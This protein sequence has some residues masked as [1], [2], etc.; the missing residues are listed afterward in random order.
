MAKLTLDLTGSAGL[1]SK[2]AGDLNDTIE[3]P[4]LRYLVAPG[5][6]ADGIYDP[7]RV[8]GYLSPAN[9]TYT[10]LTGT[11]TNDII[12]KAYSASAD[13]VYLAENGVK[14]G[15]LNT[16]SDTSLVETTFFTENSRFRDTEIYQMN[17]TEALLYSWVQ[18]TPSTSTIANLHLGFM[19]I[20]STKGAFQ[21]ASQVF[22]STLPTQQQIEQI[23]L[24]S[25]TRLGQSFLTNDFFTTDFKTVSGIRLR[26]EMPYVSVNQTW[27]LQVSIQTDS[28]GFPSGTDVTGTVVTLNPN[29]LPAGAF[30][31]VYFTFTNPVNLTASTKYHI[32]LKSTA[33]IVAANQGVYWLST[34]GNNSVYTNGQT[35]RYDGTTWSKTDASN[36][37]FDFALITNK[38]NYIGSSTQ[39]LTVDGGLP[40]LGTN[41]GRNAGTTVSTLATTITVTA[42]INS[43]ILIGVMI[44]TAT[45]IL[46][47]ITCSGGG[48]LTLVAKQ[49]CSPGSNGGYQYMYVATGLTAGTN[50]VTVNT[51]ANT[52]ITVLLS[53]YYNID[54]TNP[55]PYLNFG[56]SS[57][58]ASYSLTV[59]V[60]PPPSTYLGGIP[61]M[62]AH[63]STDNGA[64]TIQP[65][66]GTT[67]RI[68]ATDN[69]SMMGNANVVKFGPS[70]YSLGVTGTNGGPTTCFYYEIAATLVAPIATQV[71]SIVPAI[72]EADDASVFL[73]AA[74]NGLAYWFTNNRVHK[75]DGSLTGGNSGTF[76]ADVLLFPTYIRA[77]DA[78]DYNSLVYIGI[79]SS[80]VTEPDYRTF[81]DYPCGIYS[82]DYQSILSTIRNYQPLPGARNIKRIFLNADGDVRVITIGGNRFTEIRGLV[83]GNFEVLFTLGLNAYPVHRD[84]FDYIDNMCIWLGADGITY[85]LGKPTSKLSYNYGVPIN[86]GSEGVF[87]IGDISALKGGATTI[88]PLI[89]FTGNTNSSQS[90]DG[91]LM[92]YSTTTSGVETAKLARWYPHGT[93]TISSVAQQPNAGNVYSAVLMFPT[94]AKVNYIRIFHAPVGTPSTTVKGNITTYVNQSTTQS[95]SDSVTSQLISKGYQYI[96]LGQALTSGVFALQFKFT[97]VTTET[98]DQNA[99]WMP[100]FVEVDYDEITKL[101]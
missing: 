70:A 26:L 76:T 17:G 50:T 83:N 56:N 88:T 13:T 6:M 11:I 90:L 101:F 47:T 75:L 71:T 38:Y 22:A 40:I 89:T 79:E 69:Q 27:T 39:T 1:A 7:L 81:P 35:E 95:R 33:A 61:V 97:W 28:A 65:G 80:N 57:Q 51:S 46:T 64:N 44:S 43:A 21:V 66:T 85:A 8:Q 52:N 19:S 74:Q 82:W 45:D 53:D 18:N 91:M 41:T 100:R 87:K 10:A 4:Q 49:L 98:L 25:N 2:F 3:Q 68:I 96:K 36:E 23:S 72:T 42:E 99:D 20:D 32:V 78:V 9:N 29:N 63:L 55:A 12:S 59:V 15:I 37:S 93:G 16:L 86:S 5:Q 34:A 54:Q 94:L 84:S 24:T 14:L 77:V 67:T 60:P 92:A 73:H 30:D 58:G 62:F 48:T 31:F